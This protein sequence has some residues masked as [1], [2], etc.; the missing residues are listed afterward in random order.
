MNH[1]VTVADPVTESRL[2][3]I[4]HYFSTLVFREGSGEKEYYELSAKFHGK[5]RSSDRFSLRWKKVTRILHAAPE[6]IWLRTRAVLWRARIR[7]DKFRYMAVVQFL[8]QKSNVRAMRH[9]SSV[10]VS[11][12][13]FDFLLSEKLIRRVPVTQKATRE[14]QYRAV[15]FGLTPLQARLAA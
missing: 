2:P 5:H 11:D 7:A 1:N 12:A 4:P 3:N 13:D 6:A 9:V 10:T 8:D 14:E 15:I